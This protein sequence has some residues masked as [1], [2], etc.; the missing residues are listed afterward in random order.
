MMKNWKYKVQSSPKEVIQ[1][2][3]AALVSASGFIFKLDNNSESFRIR[4]PVKYPDQILHRNRII[5]NG[6]I[7]NTNS[8]NKTDIEISFTQDFYMKMTVFSI[9]IFGG[10]LLALISRISN[11]A[12]MYLLVGGVLVLGIIL[13]IA[14][15]RKLEKDTQKYKTLISE[16]LGN[17]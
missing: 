16:I 1:N 10:M 3:D 13:W 5:V 11:G 8:E 14:L 4:K 17:S 12:I 7:S 9:I 6:K 15:Q 2:L